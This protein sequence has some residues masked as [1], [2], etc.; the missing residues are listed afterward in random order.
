MCG[1]AGLIH[2][3]Q[4]P[5][6]PVILQRMTDAIAH[7]GPDGEGHWIEGGVGIGHRRLAIIDL[8]PAGHQPMVTSDHRY[9]LSYNGEIYNYREL[10][11]ELEAKGYWFRSNTDSEVLLYALTHWGTDALPRLNGMFAFAL[12]DRKQRKLLL[13]RDRYGIKPLYFSRFGKSFA[14]ASEQ[15]AI[16]ILP[17]FEQRVDRKALLEYFTFQNIF[18]DRT[19]VEDV[20]L[21]PAGHWAELDLGNADPQLVRHQYWDFDFREPD[22]PASDDEYREEL[23]RSVPAG[24]IASA[25]QRRRTR[26]LSVR[27]HGFRIDHGRR[28]AV[29]SVPENL[30]LRF[31]PQFCFGHGAGLRRARQSRGDVVPLQDRAL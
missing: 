23:D 21:L 28:G 30:H 24:G 22:Q 14:F 17:G 10:R 25:G 11:A 26:Q 7:R 8:S 5:V 1:I 20:C 9:I 4:E 19:L 31:R 2:L 15:K 3:D 12:W 29:V 6:S 16:T 27:R 13:G 18:T